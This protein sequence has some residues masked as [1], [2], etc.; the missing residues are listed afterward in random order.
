MASLKQLIR[1]GI[2]GSLLA[3]AALTGAAPAAAQSR[4]DARVVEADLRALDY[5]H[6]A[7]IADCNTGYFDRSDRLGRTLAVG[8][9]V[10]ECRTQAD[11][12]H[13]YGRYRILMRAGYLRD[14]ASQLDDA[15]IKRQLHDRAEYDMDIARCNGRQIDGFSRRGRDLGDVF[16][17]SARNGQC[18]ARARADYVRAQSSTEDWAASQL[19]A[20]TNAV[21]RQRGR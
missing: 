16:R 10:R 14:A 15:Y 12:D 19:R 3:G 7:D 11:Y 17:D 5:E 21:Q 1:A 18:T 9:E 20:L 6:Q 2:A 4:A 13:S 8:P